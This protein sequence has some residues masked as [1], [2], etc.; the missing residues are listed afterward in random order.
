M[1]AENISG[2]KSATRYDIG[3]SRAVEIVLICHFNVEARQSNFHLTNSVVYF[4]LLNFL[5]LIVTVP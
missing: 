1:L 3:M 2:T 5:I 4:V